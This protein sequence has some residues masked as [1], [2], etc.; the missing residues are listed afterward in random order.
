MKKIDLDRA[1]P[2]TPE[3][4]TAAIRMGFAEGRRRERRRRII[5][6][7]MCAAA[8]LA[9]ALFGAVKVMGSGED[10]VAAPGDVEVRLPEVTRVYT[11]RPDR[12]YHMDEN[13][14]GGV[15]MSVEAARGF[16]KIPCPECMSAFWNSGG[17]Q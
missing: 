6:G 10:R 2:E 4:F 9:I 16:Q 5:G 14:A 3:V 15:E 8:V 1:F 13:C 11:T 12:Y 7:A 17:S